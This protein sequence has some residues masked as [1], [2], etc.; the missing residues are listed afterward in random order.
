M[1]E[2]FR[3]TVCK[4]II[5]VLFILTVVY[6]IGQ[7]QVEIRETTS[8]AQRDE[9]CIPNCWVEGFRDSS[10]SNYCHKHHVGGYCNHPSRLKAYHKYPHIPG[11]SNKIYARK[12]FKMYEAPSSSFKLLYEF[13]LT[14]YS[15]ISRRE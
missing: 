11:V 10:K 6:P 2:F 9:I 4:Q 7:E 1:N 3:R 13:V 8:T 15:S 14:M 12:T 5:N